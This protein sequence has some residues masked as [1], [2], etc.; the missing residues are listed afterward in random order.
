VTLSLKL[1][2]FREYMNWEQEDVAL[3]ISIPLGDYKALECGSGNINSEIVL[4]L[5]KLYKVPEVIFC[6][7][8]CAQDLS[9]I[10]SQCTF[11]GS[12]GY[13]NHFYHHENE[14]IRF[15]KLE[16]SRLQEHNG[17]LIKLLLDK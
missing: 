15:L 1:I 3:K 11:N 8:E 6:N 13:V 2:S 7:N 4:S 14:L 12:N 16:I 5:S 17:Q 9:I 10:Y